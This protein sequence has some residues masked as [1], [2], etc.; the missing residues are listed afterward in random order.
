MERQKVTDENVN[1]DSPNEEANITDQIKAFLKPVRPH[2]K[3]ADKDKDSNASDSEQENV[4]KESFDQL[5]KQSTMAAETINEV[6]T[7]NLSNFSTDAD[8]ELYFENKISHE[9]SEDR[10]DEFFSKFSGDYKPTVD[11]EQK[12]LDSIKISD[13]DPYVLELID[14]YMQDYVPHVPPKLLLDMLEKSMED[15]QR[16]VNCELGTK[17]RFYG[18]VLDTFPLDVSYWV[19]LL[20]RPNMK[21]DSVFFLTDVSPRKEIVLSQWYEKERR[22]LNEK[23]FTR[24]RDHLMKEMKDER[25]LVHKIDKNSRVFDEHI[26]QEEES[27]L[28]VDEVAEIN[29]TF[30]NPLKPSTSATRHSKNKLPP[31]IKTSLPSQQKFSESSALEFKKNFSKTSYANNN[32]KM[33][34]NGANNS[35][36][37][38]NANANNNNKLCYNY[39][40]DYES[41]ENSHSANHSKRSS[42]AK[43]ER[44]NFLDN[45]ISHN[46]DENVKDNKEKIEK[47]DIINEEFND[48]DRGISIVNINSNNNLNNNSIDFPD[49]VNNVN[50]SQSLQNTDDASLKKSSKQVVST[51]KTRM[52]STLSKATSLSLLSSSSAVLV[53][54]KEN[55]MRFFTRSTYAPPSDKRKRSFLAKKMRRST[56]NK[57]SFTSLAK[58]ITP[59]KS[60]SEDALNKRAAEINEKIIDVQNVF[61]SLGLNYTDG[62]D[63]LLSGLSQIVVFGVQTRKS[64]TEEIAQSCII[65]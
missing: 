42:D 40:C 34:Q 30:S 18:W 1:L 3:D 50:N 17:D 33:K 24:L 7:F 15:I 63:N 31:I 45:W 12:L 53:N 9:S 28:E 59:P 37:N 61:K 39:N 44:I 27:W 25:F 4:T 6:Q 64:I 58:K 43:T 5:R 65:V 32:N 41:H 51:K 35:N 52:Q 38:A 22:Q 47:S 29:R 11:D 56:L 55:R 10:V 36:D 48:D 16:Q 62:Y 14:N 13:T 23:M 21:P 57:L 8:N 46:E 19:A 26:E 2:E 60:T 49:N 20:R 54:P